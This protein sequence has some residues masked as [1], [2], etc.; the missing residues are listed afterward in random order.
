MNPSREAAT[1]IAGTFVSPRLG[2]DDDATVYPGLTPR[3]TLMS[4][5]RGWSRADG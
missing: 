3:A 2:L 4:P 5:L 1:P